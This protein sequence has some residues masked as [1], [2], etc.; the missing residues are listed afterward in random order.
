MPVKT[1]ERALISVYDKEG[2]VP[3]A[4]YLCRSGTIVISSGGTYKHL[5]ENGVGAVKVE[6]ITEFPE[7]LEGRVKT[8]HPRIHGGILAKRGNEAHMKAIEELGIGTIDL[9]VVNLYPFEKVAA[10][11]NASADMVLENIDIGGPSLLRAAAKNFQDVLVVTDP[12][13]YQRVMDVL[14]TEGVPM[15]L[16]TELARKA[17]EQ[18]AAYDIAITDWFS[19]NMERRTGFPEVMLGKMNFKRGLRYGENPHQAA[20][21]YERRT[22]LPSF[23]DSCEIHQGKELS[24]NNFLDLDGALSLLNEFEGE[25]ACLVVKHTNP[26]GLA[27][28]GDTKELFIRARDGDALSAFGGVIAFNV[29][30]D[31]PAAEEICAGFYEIV[32]APS[33]SK[34]ALKRFKKKKNWRIMTT[35][36]TKSGYARKALEL[37]DLQLGVLVQARDYPTPTS[38]DWE[39]VTERKPSEDEMKGLAMAWKVVKHVKSNAI[40]FANVNEILGIGMGQPSRVDAV[41]I[42]ARKSGDAAKGGCMASDAFFPFPDN[43]EVAAEAG[44]TAIIQPGGSIKDKDSIETANKLGV[45]MMFTGERHFRH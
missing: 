17:F 6:D 39:C 21:L 35:P 19:L 34:E 12:A 28:G 23:I 14:A 27:V 26:V 41:R 36:F 4:Q 9:V 15:Q 42:A 3:F 33:Y 30:V 29:E 8:M 18:T 40:V 1:I 2:I 20:A 16:R 37:K 45:A 44:I 38:N 7:M 25:E 32:V 5:V 11:P 10:D 22:E 13:D 24:F 43:V 31:E